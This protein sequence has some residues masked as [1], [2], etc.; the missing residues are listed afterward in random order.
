MEYHN[1]DSTL[2]EVDTRSIVHLGWISPR[3][4]TLK[5][6]GGDITSLNFVGLEGSYDITD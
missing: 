3:N 2:E 4:S 5:D 1:I 6:S